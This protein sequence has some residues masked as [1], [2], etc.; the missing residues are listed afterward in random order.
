MQHLRNSVP[1]LPEKAA[2]YRELGYAGSGELAQELGFPEEDWTMLIH[3]QLNLE[4]TKV[5]H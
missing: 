1:K 4:S 2:L 5:H 3:C